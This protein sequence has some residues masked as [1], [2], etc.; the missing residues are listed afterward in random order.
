MQTKFNVGDIVYL[1]YK[2]F[3][4]I[5]VRI[6][7]IKINHNEESYKLERIC[8]HYNYGYYNDHSLF[9]TFEEAKQYLIK[10]KTNKYQQDMEIILAL[11]EEGEQG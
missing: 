8:D 5:R 10:S 1:G 4:I 9:A 3:E 7:E 2:S 6:K 11:K